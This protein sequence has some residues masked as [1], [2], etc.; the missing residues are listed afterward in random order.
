M[1]TEHAE[2]ARY[3]VAEHLRA[4]EARAQRRAG[5]P[6]TSPREGL[7]GALR[8]LADKLEPNSRHLTDPVARVLTDPQP[9]HRGTGLSIVR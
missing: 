7:A 5:K 1:I 9:R 4:A 8:R 2:V 6:R 3:R